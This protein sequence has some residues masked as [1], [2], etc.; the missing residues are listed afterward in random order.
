M[1]RTVED[2]RFEQHAKLRTS[3]DDEGSC[4]LF[5]LAFHFAGARATTG[6]R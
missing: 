5:W 6:V 4:G 3:W 1:S 2:A